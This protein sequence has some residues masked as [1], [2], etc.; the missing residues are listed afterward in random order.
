[1]DW[2]ETLQMPNTDFEMRGNLPKKEPLIL[3]K[4]EDEKLYEV[5]MKAHQ[6]DES[7]IL[8]DGPPYANNNLHMGTAMNRVIKDFILKSHYLA[9]Y[10]T[11][12]YPGWDTH[13]LPIENMM[14]KLGFDRKKMTTAEFRTECQKYA[15]AQVAIQMSTEKRLGC[16][17]DYEH[18]YLTYSKEYEAD[19]VRSFAKMAMQGLVYQGLK[20][21]YWSPERESAV[22]DTETYYE[23][24]TDDTIYVSFDVVDTKGVL[25][26]DEKFV[27]W[28]TTPWTIPADLAIALNPGFTYAVVN[29]TKG[30]LIV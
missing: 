15:Q 23:D 5:M 27:I 1:M 10:N 18:P 16:L 24:K 26:G 8:H 20:P 3:K 9:G 14:P 11:P 22:A 28:T 7:F 30:K 21:I 17:A 4:W 13:G 12:F 2:K 25:D 19:E 6:H 29:T